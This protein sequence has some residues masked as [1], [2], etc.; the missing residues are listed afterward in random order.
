MGKTAKVVVCGARGVGKT[1]ILEQ[2]IHGH[3]NL[4]TEFYPTIE[5]IYPAS[6]TTDKGSKELVRFLDTAGLGLG[7]SSELSRHYF[8]T[9]DGYVIIYDPDETES[10]NVVLNIKKD[11]EKYREKKEVAVTVLANRRRG[12]RAYPVDGA[13]AA[14]WASREKVRLHE[15]DAM[16]RST[17]FEPFTQLATRLN[18]PQ[19][20]SA[21]S[22]LGI[23]R[24]VKETG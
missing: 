14:Q 10:F 6:V 8:G 17:L 21:F 11:I 18:P 1:A 2:L 24:K 22:Q 5:D 20:K 4:K 3:V 19:Q 7:Y 16:D 9:A 23:S 15:V 13:Q 12:E